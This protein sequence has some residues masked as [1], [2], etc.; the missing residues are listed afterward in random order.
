MQLQEL[1]KLVEYEAVG[2]LM[3]TRYSDGWVLVALKGEYKDSKNITD[4]ALELARG[5]L[6]VF[7]TLDALAKLVKTDLNNLSFKVF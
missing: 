7:A 6:R 4:Y 1:K 2:T 3:A 5:G